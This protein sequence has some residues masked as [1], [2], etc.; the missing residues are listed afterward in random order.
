MASESNLSALKGNEGIFLP[1]VYLSRCSA[2]AGAICF[3][4]AELGDV[5]LRGNLDFSLP[6]TRVK[7]A[8][9]LCLVGDFG[10][11]KISILPPSPELN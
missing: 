10:N 9:F 2:T 7:L 5:L 8:H 3:H 11:Y 6:E 4:A 1:F